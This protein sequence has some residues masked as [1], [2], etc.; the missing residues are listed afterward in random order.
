MS[1]ALNPHCKG[2]ASQRS[3]KRRKYAFHRKPSELAGCNVVPPSASLSRELGQ[4]TTEDHWIGKTFARPR[5]QL[6]S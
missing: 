6:E 3:Q 1:K 2:C 4:T 5:A